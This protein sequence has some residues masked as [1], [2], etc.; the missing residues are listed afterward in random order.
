MIVEQIYRQMVD[1]ENKGLKP[2]R[3]YIGTQTAV[4]LVN[5][6]CFDDIDKESDGT[7][8]YQGVPIYRVVDD[9]HLYVTGIDEDDLPW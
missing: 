2:D 5:E 3:I 7:F 9:E 4:E 8:K 6:C 1:L